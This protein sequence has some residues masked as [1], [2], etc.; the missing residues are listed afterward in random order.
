MQAQANPFNRQAL[1]V[2]TITAFIV[3][4]AATIDTL[5]S[6][7]PDKMKV[8][9]SQ[10]ALE[11]LAA[12]KPP[13]TSNAVVAASTADGEKI[14]HSVCFACHDSGAANAPKLGDKTAWQPRIA[15]GKEALYASALQGKNAMPARGGNPKLSDA[16]VKATVDW[17]VS[18]AE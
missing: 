11:L 12:A 16:D 10:K 2:I 5:S 4:M 15:T 18:Q 8:E 1:S 6:R 9:P 17:M 3:L 14:Y 7:P 13:T